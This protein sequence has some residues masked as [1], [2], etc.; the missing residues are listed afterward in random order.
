MTIEDSL[1]AVL[2]AL[3]ATE[4]PHMVVGSFSTN[5]YGR[6]RSTEDADLVVQVGPKTISQLS[7]KIGKELKIDPQMS[8][9]TATGTMRHIVEVVGTEFKIELFHLSDDDHDQERFRRRRRVA[10]LG[11]EVWLPT[12]EDVIVTKLRWADRACRKKDRNDLQDVIA[13]RGKKIDWDYVNAWADRHG[14]RALLDE[15]RNSIPPI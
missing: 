12:V 9:E 15:I 2:Q 3:E 7:E 14:T 13:V 8:F 5:F 11:R 1:V 4:T 10:Y 6:R